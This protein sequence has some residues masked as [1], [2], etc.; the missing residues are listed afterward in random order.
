M[1]SLLS[2]KLDPP[3]SG[4]DAAADILIPGAPLIVSSVEAAPVENRGRLRY[5]PL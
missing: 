3:F 4:F 1:T 5:A 2:Y